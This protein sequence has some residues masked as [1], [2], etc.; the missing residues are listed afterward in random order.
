VLGYL[1]SMALKAPMD[2][3]L[4]GVAR[5]GALVPANVKI[6]EIDPRR[7]GASWTG[8]DERRRTIAAAVVRASG[9]S[10]AGRTLVASADAIF[11]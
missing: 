6:V 2:G 9:K 7:R 5:D 8:T 4:R 10:P 1:D 3:F 11:H